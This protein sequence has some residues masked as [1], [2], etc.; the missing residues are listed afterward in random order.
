MKPIRNT[1]LIWSGR[2]VRA[3]CDRCGR[4]AVGI[5]GGGCPEVV[6]ESLEILA[7]L[8]TERLGWRAR[9]GELLCPGCDGRWCN[10]QV[11]WAGP[12]FAE[13]VD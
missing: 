2:T 8:A 11:A 1:K 3:R 10:G 7:V 9:G 5:D 12:V 13:A 6:S 4:R